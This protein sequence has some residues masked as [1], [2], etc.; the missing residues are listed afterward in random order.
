MIARFVQLPLRNSDGLEFR[1]WSAWVGFASGLRRSVPGFGGFLQF[2]SATFHGD[3]ERV[4]LEIN[5][6]YSGS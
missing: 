4:D 5:S 1:E 6:L 3:I 2:F